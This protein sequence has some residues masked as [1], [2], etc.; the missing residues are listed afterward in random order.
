MSKVSIVFTG[1]CIH[2]WDKRSN[3]YKSFEKSIIQPIVNNYEL[4]IVIGCSSPKEEKDWQDN[5]CKKLP[6]KVNVLI[7]NNIFEHDL[8][9]MKN[10]FSEEFC[11]HHDRENYMCHYG[12]Y[13][14]TI[15]R[16]MLEENFKNTDYILKL[17]YDIIYH[18]EDRF[19]TQWFRES[20][21][22]V[23]C[24][25]ST[26]FHSPGRW[27]ER[28]GEHG[29]PNIISDQF[30]FSNKKNMILFSKLYGSSE[31]DY[32][33]KINSNPQKGIESILANYIL[34]HNIKCAAVEIRFTNPGKI[35]RP[36][37]VEKRNQNIKKL[38]Y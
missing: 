10:R 38:N 34:F 8:K 21:K 29:Y 35:R 6:E 31:I 17:R 22:N 1:P 36:F 11:I 19:D 26:E 7:F 32:S 13:F 14:E 12:K 28:E 33:N 27:S 25:G 4:D 16:M 23:F 15:K 30:I 18:K 37:W 9:S 2:N 3:Y 20:D 24:I 5:L